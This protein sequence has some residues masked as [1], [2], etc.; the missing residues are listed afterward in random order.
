MRE[1]SL[2]FE[3]ITS[4]FTLIFPNGGPYDFFFCFYVICKKWIFDINFDKKKNL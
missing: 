1:M 3:E 4:I 2:L